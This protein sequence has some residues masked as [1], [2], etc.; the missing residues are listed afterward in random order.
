MNTQTQPNPTQPNPLMNAPAPPKG[1]IFLRSCAHDTILAMLCPSQ[2][3]A[4]FF[5]CCL[6]LFESF[7]LSHLLCLICYALLCPS[8]FA[9]LSP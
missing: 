4:N 8:L 6:W 5:A 7:F 2:K 1:L 9:L 3:T